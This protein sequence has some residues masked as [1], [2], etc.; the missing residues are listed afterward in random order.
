MYEITGT[1]KILLSDTVM[2]R[3]IAF[4]RTVIQTKCMVRIRSIQESV[5]FK[6]DNCT[7]GQ[8]IPHFSCNAPVQYHISNTLP[9]HPI[10][11]QCQPIPSRHSR[12]FQL[13]FS[14]IPPRVSVFT[15]V[16]TFQVCQ[17]N[18]VR[19]SHFVKAS[20]KP[21]PLHP[22]RFYHSNSTGGIVYIISCCQPNIM[23]LAS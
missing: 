6:A 5:F 19:I 9:L 17:L 14:S 2:A 1:G 4:V 3:L 20:D 7:A 13:Y 16:S 12:S 10:R 15:V 23:L 11:R 18:P 22:P 8:Q 21:L